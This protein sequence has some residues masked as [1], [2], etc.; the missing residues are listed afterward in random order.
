MTTFAETLRQ[1]GACSEAL[2]W[3]GQRTAADAWRE[4]KSSEWMLWLFGHMP[5]EITPQELRLLACDFAEAAVQ[6]AD[7]ETAAVCEGVI[8]VARRY[9]VGDA[10]D[11]EL[12]AAM[13]AAWAAAGAAAGDA[14]R[15]AAWDAARAAARA[16]QCD[17]IRAAVAWDRVEAALGKV[18]T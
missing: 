12:A 13:D 1:I 2:A 8:K 6:Y 11:E 7:E 15:A 16:A 4:C 18:P 3:V 17:M 10:S 5:I 9:A 14:A